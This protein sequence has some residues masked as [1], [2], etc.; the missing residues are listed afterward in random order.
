MRRLKVLWR[1]DYCDGPATWTLIGGE[2]YY[3]CDDGCDEFM[4]ME[5]LEVE[6]VEDPVR[7]GDAVDT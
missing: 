7:G 5:L 2:V 3:H 1:C 4:Q 6:R